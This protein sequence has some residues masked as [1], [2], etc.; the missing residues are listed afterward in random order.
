ML[1][2][3]LRKNIMTSA[4]IR[5]LAP[6]ELRQPVA[7][8]NGST[9]L[10]HCPLCNHTISDQTIDE[11]LNT[12]SPMQKGELVREIFNNHINHFGNSSSFQLE[13]TN[14]QP[15]VS[16]RPQR[17]N[18]DLNIQHYTMTAQ[19]FLSNMLNVAR[20]QAVRVFQITTDVLQH[21][22]VS[23][24]T[25]LRQ[26]MRRTVNPFPMNFTP[27][28]T[29][30]D[31]DND[32]INEPSNTSNFPISSRVFTR[33][34]SLRRRVFTRNPSLRERIFSETSLNNISIIFSNL[35]IC[36]ATIY[37]GNKI[38][39]K[40]FRLDETNYIND[41]L[42]KS[43]LFTVLTSISIATIKNLKNRFGIYFDVSNNQIC[44]G[45]VYKFIGIGIATCATLLST[46]KIWQKVKNYF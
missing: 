1:F 7:S 10:N 31:D 17:T 11:L 20:P 26:F 3:I 21:A 9:R 36:Y 35:C 34:A 14:I 8:A 25:L 18:F 38:S 32:P 45:S 19:A 29:D 44:K 46:Q 42:I 28:V 37:I 13:R 4:I 12:L 33:L 6:S 5:D 43:G 15:I 30:S 40:L 2:E 24:R 22:S 23:T 16:D 39:T 41:L 27:I